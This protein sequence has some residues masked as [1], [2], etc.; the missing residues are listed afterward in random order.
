MRSFLKYLLIILITS[1]VTTV[2]LMQIAPF[3]ILV[4]NKDTQEIQINFDQSVTKKRLKTVD[5]KAK[6]L[7]LLIGDGMGINQVTAYRIA[8]GGPNYI[9]AFDKF[10]FTGLIK[11]HAVDTLITDSAASATA[12]SSGIKTVNGYLGVNKDKQAV[13]N[14]TEMLYEKGYVTSLIATSEITHATPAA[15][16]VHNESRDNTDQIAEAMFRSNNFISLGGGRDF[17]VPEDLGGQREDNFDILSLIKEEESYLESKGDFNNFQFDPSKRIFGLFAK[18]GFVREDN[19]PNLLEMFNFT[20]EQSKKMLV[21]N[22]A[23]F[24]IMTEGS[25]IDWEGHENDFN[26]VF[27]EMDEF[28]QVVNRALEYAK[29]DQNTLVIV[30]SDHETGGLLI[31]TDDW[32]RDPEPSN[33]MKISWNTAVGLGTHTGTM[34]PAFAF[35]PGAENIAGVMD[36]TDI[37]FIMKEA[38]GL[39]ELSDRQC[40]NKVK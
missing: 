35:G 32:N 8:K 16:T 23:G 2:G 4:P 9:S 27:K 14:I 18:E 6:N 7:I 30:L 38:L 21:N 33:K 13:K 40:S 19:E 17:F 3:I 34:I 24:F 37:F 26:G 1:S 15:F 31:E 25:Q 12:Y 22:C 39:D 20:L 36:N 28:D 5:R 29:S 10:P 11:T